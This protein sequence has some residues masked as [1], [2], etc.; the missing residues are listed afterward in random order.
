MFWSGSRPGSA[1]T[2][3]LSGPVPRP[4]SALTWV[5]S[6]P[7]F[8]ANNIVKFLLGFT[9]KGAENFMVESLDASFRYPQ[10][11]IE[12]DPVEPGPVTADGTL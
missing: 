6:P 4:G 1:L 9:N 7:D 12:P 10:V 11:L 5:L 8:P 3:V 2:L